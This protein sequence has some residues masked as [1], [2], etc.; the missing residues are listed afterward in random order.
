MIQLKAL[1]LD[2]EKN[3]C[4]VIKS[5]LEKEFPEIHI[6]WCTDIK[7]APQKI[8][9]IQPDILFL[10]IQFPTGTGFDILSKSSFKNFKLIM[11]TAYD[12]HALEAFR[13]RASA[14]L[15]KP[16]NP[17]EFKEVVGEVI[18]LISVEKLQSQLEG[19]IEAFIEINHKGSKHKININN[20][21]YLKAEA[22]YTRI[23]TNYNDF[24]IARTLK[25]SAEQLSYV[26]FI[27]CHQSYV[28]NIHFM[29]VY[30]L[31]T[32]EI[33]LIDGTKIPVS[34][35]YRNEVKEFIQTK[36]SFLE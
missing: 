5:F 35:K 33:V 2:D 21:L 34:R 3:S 27:R 19:N 28:V 15:L 14:Y 8:D 4:I 22:N 31:S 18:G 9:L 12:E 29:E 6:S 1:I 20:I 26:V 32:D 7:I 16:I 30:Q 23:V 11:T 36:G 13:A 25:S 24:L 17:R 10:D